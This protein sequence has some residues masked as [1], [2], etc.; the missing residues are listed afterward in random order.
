MSTTQPHPHP[1]GEA[2]LLQQVLDRTSECLCVLDVEGRVQVWNG[3]MERLTGVAARG[4]VDRPLESV[5]SA[6]AG[7]AQRAA[8][9]AA[10]AGAVSE[11]VPVEVHGGAMLDVSPL[12]AGDGSVAGVVMLVRAAGVMTGE[13]EA[14]R[15]QARAATERAELA[16]DAAGM[17]TW[18]YDFKARR[19][20]LSAGMAAMLG[21]AATALTLSEEELN[22]VVHPDGLARK[23]DDMRRAVADPHGRFATENRLRGADGGYVW[24][25]C[26]GRVDRNAAGEPVILRAVG[27]NV[28]RQRDLEAAD[29][30]KAELLAMAARAARIAPMLVDLERGT[31]THGPEVLELMGLPAD[32]PQITR[33]QW[34]AA[35]HPEDLASATQRLNH[36]FESGAPEY[37]NAYRLLLPDG[38]VRWIRTAL[39]IVRGAGGK[40][41]RMVGVVSD[42]SDL[43][44]ARRAAQDSSMSMSLVQETGATGTWRLTAEGVFAYDAGFAAILRMSGG[45]GAMSLER[46]LERFHPE[47]REATV[48]SV[49]EVLAGEA[50]RFC[51]EHRLMGDDARY[52][53]LRCRGVA[54]RD[55]RGRVV[56][57]R[58]AT[59]DRTPIVE[60]DASAREAERRVGLAVEAAGLGEWTWDLGTGMVRCNA[61]KLA[62]LGIAGGPADLP[63]ER[64]IEQS[65]YEDKEG[66]RRAMA[67]VLAGAQEFQGA[68]RR[69][70]HPDGSV[71]WVRSVGRRMTDEAGRPTDRVVGLTI[72]IT[73]TRLAMETLERSNEELEGLVRARTEE[74]SR[75]HEHLRV[76]ERLAA[77]GTLAAGL[78]HDLGNLLLPI[79][80]ELDV[81]RASVSDSPS[82]ERIDS[83][84]RATEYLARLSQSLRMLALD[85]EEAGGS[86]KG[87]SVNEWWRT[88]EPLLR[89]ALPKGIVFEA[90]IAAGLPRVKPGGPGLSQATFNLLLNAAEAVRTTRSPRIELVATRSGGDGGVELSVAD[91]GV[92]M[93]DEVKRRAT[94]PFFTTKPR[95]LS[96]GLGLSLVESILRGVGGT[97]AITSS[98]GAGTE[99]KLSLPVAAA[100]QEGPAC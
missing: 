90:K 23:A 31:I 38:R 49:R 29:R 84:R 61:R 91:N 15:S 78:G 86:D 99:V 55:E 48:R 11:R 98:P 88:A 57:I 17:A 54:E 4:A 26:C 2:L 41:V 77:V 83:V 63:V 20:T 19:Y 43:H 51:N 67:A 69:V 12:R 28:A 100:A 97:L 21:Y 76:S 13:L 3:A 58:G 82:R 25:R 64:L 45:A 89:S 14:A 85:P 5:W 66:V 1:P 59:C 65:H 96:T 68:E 39:A 35:I 87:I 81:L 6:A 27:Q 95:S 7:A 32:H 46:L 34:R 8:V 18:S 44:E 93:S 50:E 42:V 36:Q 37:R 9:A 92:G 62:M 74:L 70:V 16:L 75:S 33:E 40:P 60:S 72:D 10:L 53:W 79:R 56:A 52:H 22:G 80:C 24:F 71:R 30:E 73:E 94:E 47:G